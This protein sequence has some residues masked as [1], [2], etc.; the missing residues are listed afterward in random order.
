VLQSAQTSADIRSLGDVNSPQ[1]ELTTQLDRHLEN[2]VGSIQGAVAEG[3]KKR[4]DEA[5][6]TMAE[7]RKSLAELK[8]VASGGEATAA[9]SKAFEA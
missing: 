4:L 1:M 5:A 8:A 2:L 9:L 3:E 7:A 6:A